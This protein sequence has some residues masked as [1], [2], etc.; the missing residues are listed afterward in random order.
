[1]SPKRTLC[2]ALS[3]CSVVGG[4]GLPALADSEQPQP[5]VNHP[6]AAARDPL[7]AQFVIGG[8]ALNNR[9]YEAAVAIFADLLRKTNSPRVKLE[10]ARALFLARRYKAAKQTFNEVLSEAELPWAVKQNIR[11]Y[12]DEIDSFLGFV[13]FGLSIVSD[14]NP[15]NFT[16]SKEVMI[17]GQVLSVVPPEDN[18]EIY[19]IRYK[20]T[21]GRP[22]SDDRRVLGFLNLSYTDFEQG[23]FDR[24]TG[25]TGVIYTFKSLPK[26]RSRTGV[27]YSAQGGNKQYDFSYTSLL[28]T[29]DP[30]R[31]FRLNHEF[32]VGRLHSPNAPQFDATSYS[33][34]TNFSRP[35][36]SGALVTSVVSIDHSRAKEDPYSYHGGAIGLGIDI[37]LNSWGLE[38]FGSAG[39]R[40]YEE[41]DPFFEGKRSDSRKKLGLL[42]SNK[43]IQIMNFMPEIGVVYE[44]ND[45]SLDFFSYDKLSLVFSLEE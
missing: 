32:K 41:P 8:I 21:S 15:R 13:K 23:Q 3:L 27:E 37:P 33:L 19:G 34:I 45:S 22:L 14:S 39:K 42:L 4:G 20:M 5:A 43:N 26:L 10:L 29:P 38:L 17:A 36:D 6:K 28:Y 25:D 35:L 11:L 7:Q 44:R 16:S 24:W 18:R 31:Q 12:L 30:V 40:L 2:A 1:M 9:D